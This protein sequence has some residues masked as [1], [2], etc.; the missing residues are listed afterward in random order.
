MRRRMAK[1]GGAGRLRQPW[2][3][4]RLG[5]ELKRRIKPVLKTVDQSLL[6]GAGITLYRRLRGTARV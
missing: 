3:P 5:W 2:W 1:R 4:K 6:G